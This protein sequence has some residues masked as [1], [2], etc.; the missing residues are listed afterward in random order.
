M[1]VH[2]N[3]N[4]AALEVE[5]VVVA[6]VVIIFHVDNANLVEETVDDLIYVVVAVPSTVASV[7]IAVSAV[8]GDAI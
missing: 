7:L 3:N 8:D 4:D 6:G 1:D 5:V 2:D